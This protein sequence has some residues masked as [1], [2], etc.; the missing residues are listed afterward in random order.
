MPLP[1]N[2]SWTL[3]RRL[4]GD[5][6]DNLLPD[7]TAPGLLP[8]IFEPAFPTT[9]SSPLPSSPDNAAGTG[10]GSSS[11][12][13]AVSS[14]VTIPNGSEGEIAF[15]SG[16]A[17]NAT[18]AATAYATWKHDYT[19]HYTSD[20]AKYT[21]IYGPVHMGGVADAEGINDKGQVV[22]WYVDNT[23][24]HPFVATGGDY[25]TATSLPDDPNG[26]GATYAEGINNNGV[27]VGY[28]VD[29]NGIDH[30]YI[31]TPGAVQPFV[32]L[33]DPLAAGNPS[34]GRGT[35]A[36]GINDAGQVVGGFYYGTT[37]YT[38][39]GFVYTPGVS[40]PYATLFGPP[41]GNGGTVIGAQGINNAG[42]IV[43]SYQYNNA[44]HG[45]LYSGGNYATLDG[46]LGQAGTLAS[47]ISNQGQISG[48]YYDSSNIR[49]GYLYTNG[50]YTSIITDNLAGQGG[51]NARGVNNAGQ[52]V[53]YYVDP[54][55][56]EYGFIYGPGQSITYK[57]GNT[58][59]STS[60]TPGTFTYWFG[61]SSWQPGQQATVLAGL[62][63]WSDEANITFAQA[64]NAQST[65]VT[66]YPTT[67]SSQSGFD[68][69]KI[70]TTTIGSGVDGS[71]GPST[72]TGIYLDF[73][74]ANSF[75]I[76]LHEEGH[77]IGLGHAGPYDSASTPNI[78]PRQAQFG[79][80][81]STLWTVMSYIDPGDKNAHY[82][83]S[84][85]VETQW[86]F[87]SPKTPMMLDILAAQRIYGAP[88]S[89]PL[90]SGGQIFGFHCNVAG[91]AE[92]YFD[93]TNNTS[94]VI[95][96]WDGGS[97]NTL[98]LSGFSSNSTISLT[99]GKF[100]S[101]A[102]MVNNIGIAEGTIINTAI[103]GKGNDTFIAGSGTGGN[104]PIAGDAAALA[105]GTASYSFDGG[106]GWNVA[107]FSVA[108]SGAT[109]TRNAN[110]T[111]IVAYSG[112]SYTF[113]NVDS[114]KFSDKPVALRTRAPDDFAQ[115]N[116]SDILFRKDATGD[117]WFEAISNGAF[118]GWDKVGGSNT[119]YG[120]VGT[121]DFYGNGA[122]NILFRNSATGDAWFEAISNGAFAGWNQIG[123]S[124]TRYSVAG[125]GDFYG[126]GTSDILYRNSSTG[127]TWLE[128]MSNGAFAGWHQVGGSDT[129]YSALGVG[130]FDGNGTSDIL[131]RNNSTGDT[132]F[133]AMSNGAFGGWHQIGGSDTRYSV[134]GVGDFYGNGTSDI[135]YR[136][137]STG[138]IWFAAMSNGAFAGWHQVGGSNTSYSAVG[139]GDYFGSGTDDILFRNSSSGDTWY[140][141]M[142]N[143][144]FAGWHQ[145][146]SSDPT[147]G[148][149][150]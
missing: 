137:S 33:D 37:A 87:A 136:N 38:Q 110:G 119:A 81:D 68:P 42:Q 111:T 32:T 104:A 83:N 54:T 73:N 127:D 46:P 134:V 48:V 109:L 130:D 106:A 117:T 112:G 133:E 88:T 144:G 148:V 84:Y 14:S 149:K 64:D 7:V 62:E 79:V 39:Y 126:N 13:S 142:S 141:A 69:A 18:M 75:D 67:G 8:D 52:V 97:N 138:D 90:A 129:R 98:D 150:T 51:T 121:G 120:A 96:I 41:A 99:P 28:Y 131:Y 122:C 19:A 128:A 36:R 94:P 145:V 25:S 82:Y 85:P 21:T 132:W 86:G 16:V 147:Y 3:R 31:Y 66:F 107:V 124:D 47:G 49:H 26:I 123:G 113:T 70:V 139:V 17:S 100:T 92:P 35:W 91:A 125:I 135:L 118:A 1:A 58:S 30:G 103:G 114:V 27:I 146:G 76:L 5:S 78:D 102:G 115:T 80:Y 143:G 6:S 65:N 55:P 4:F 2:L 10:A 34:F 74:V 15:I 59:L 45:F 72:G 89:G 63:L 93:F 11:Q 108:S 9:D 95:T 61:T 23:G 101:C 43:G 140:A 56:A 22:G 77:V 50:S 20:D 53:G 60:G 71:P 57:W 24:T 105:A 40:Q 44:I 116:T 12:P 29:S